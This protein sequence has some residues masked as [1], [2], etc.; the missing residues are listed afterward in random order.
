MYCMTDRILQIHNL[1]RRNL[2]GHIWRLYF[3]CRSLSLHLANWIA[4][5][6]VDL[7]NTIFV[8]QD[9]VEVEFDG[10]T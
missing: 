3:R 8:D 4:R 1:S 6:K 7:V 2:C 10:K 5:R 9:T